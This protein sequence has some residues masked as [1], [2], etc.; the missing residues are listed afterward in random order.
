M[1]NY[2][3]IIKIEPED[4]EQIQQAGQEVGIVK[5]VINGSSG[6]SVIWVS[7]KPFEYNEVKWETQYGIYAST[8]EIKNGATIFKSS[9]ENPVKTD[10]YYPFEYG[11]FKSPTRNIGDRNQYG[12]ENNYSEK[13]TFGMAQSVTAN[14][15]KFEAR[16]LNA[17]TV[18]RQETAVFTPIEIVKVF[19][20]GEFDNGVIISEVKSNALE[21]NL[22]KNPIRTIA[23]NSATSSFVAAK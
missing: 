5:K 9:A 12:I 11:R 14:G 8:T 15:N 22:T 19:L 18:L 4:V 13:L 23:F 3:L 7:F 2:E 20:H 17:V 10:F 21:V 6:E 1:S 16:P